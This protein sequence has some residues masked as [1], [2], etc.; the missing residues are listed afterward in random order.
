MKALAKLYRR[1]CNDPRADA[2][3][4][5][6]EAPNSPSSCLSGSGNGQRLGRKMR[7]PEE[8]L[9]DVFSFCGRFVLDNMNTVSRQFD[10]TI[11]VADSLRSVDIVALGYDRDVEAYQVVFTSTVYDEDDT[12]RTKN[13]KVQLLKD[14]GSAIQ[15]ADFFF[16]SL[17]F[18]FVETFI[19]IERFHIDQTFVDRLREIKQ[20]YRRLG[21]ESPRF[22][23]VTV[24]D[25][26]SV[27]DVLAAFPSVRLLF[28]DSSSHSLRHLLLKRLEINDVFLHLLAIRG[29]WKVFYL[30]GEKLTEAGI[31]DF[32][33]DDYE[34]DGKGRELYAQSVTLSPQFLTNITK[35]RRSAKRDLL[36]D[37][38]LD[39][40]CH[41]GLDELTLR[42]PEK[43]GSMRCWTFQFMDLRNFGIHYQMCA[44]ATAQL[45]FSWNCIFT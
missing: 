3:N 21:E 20:D 24:A 38:I 43:V 13:K 8:S 16:R 45:R 25:D 32:A 7:L 19:R 30:P 18:C 33:F 35:R 22:S 9:M 17:R 12:W 41:V 31:L 15:V 4:A 36:V 37:V 28:F 27:L 40:P 14:V 6:V 42:Q 34:D 11:R 29:I 10:A 23:E 39:M 1:F 2:L 44:G 26:V 5:M